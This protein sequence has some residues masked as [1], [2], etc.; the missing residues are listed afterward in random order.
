MAFSTSSPSDVTA[1][2][3]IPYLEWGPILAGAIA[4][5]AI[6][7]LLLSF[8]AAIGLTL[9]S[10]WPNTGA[11]LWVVALAVAWYALAVQIAAF[12]AGGYLAGRMRRPWVESSGEGEFRDN[13][14]GLMVWAV[15]VLVG[16]LLLGF[17]SGAALRTATQ[18]AATVAGGAASGAANAAVLSTTPADYATDL[19][20]RPDGSTAG[21]IPAA[22]ATP[23]QRDSNDPAVRAEAGRIFTATIRNQEFSARDRDY[24]VRVVQSRTGLPEAEAQRRVDAA[25][26]EARDV[27]I[28]IREQADKARKAAIVTGF[29]AAV[30][31]LLS[32]AVACFTASIGGRHRNEG[33]TPLFYGHR[34]W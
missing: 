21:Q 24:L 12:A 13:V 18:S 22:Q 28:K 3:T 19:L 2:R 20:L 30:S 1:T 6:S 23:A 25:V 9:T 26:N 27:E 34:F 11:R 14:H 33:R 8:G 32:L 5:A 29:I 31:L 17:T 10:P 7:F 16:A 15:G 4:A